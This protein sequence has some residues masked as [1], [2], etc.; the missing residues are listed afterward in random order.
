MVLV[1][2]LALPPQFGH[3]TFTHLSITASGDSPVPVGSYFFTFGNFTGRSFSATATIPQVG[4][5]TSGIG[6]PQYLCL[7][8]TQSRSLY[9]TFLLANPCP[10]SQ[11][12]MAVLASRVVMPLNFPESN[13]IP[14]PLKQ[15]SRFFI[16][17]SS[18]PS[19]GLSVGFKGILYFFA[20]TKSRSSCA[21]ANTAPVP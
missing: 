1:S 2:R 4:Q 18:L 15:I 6:S 8:N 20:N 16:L 12:V 9:W 13:S 3:F 5:W 10:A 7:L 11:F 17:S 19:T 14:S 21:S